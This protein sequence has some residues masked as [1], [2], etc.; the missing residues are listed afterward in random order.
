MAFVQFGNKRINIDKIST[1]IANRN[2]LTI[3]FLGETP[4]TSDERIG[5][6]IWEMTTKAQFDDVIS[7]LDG[8]LTVQD[9]SPATIEQVTNIQVNDVADNNDG[10]DLSVSFNKASDETNI[11]AYRIFVAKSAQVISINDVENITDPNKFFEVTPTGSNISTALAETTEDID[12]D[13]ITNSTPYN[14]YVLS[15]ADGAN[16]VIN[17]LAGPSPEVTLS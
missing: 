7:N 3:T 10:R 2:A 5:L 4:T 15:V 6:D 1:V 8:Q 16:A 14:V 12:G 11:V 13:L 17:Q 9:F